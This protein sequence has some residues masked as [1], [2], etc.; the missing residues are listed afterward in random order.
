MRNTRKAYGIAILLFFLAFILSFSIGRYPIAPFELIKI[1]FSRIIPIERTW[2]SQMETVVFNI[3]LPRVVLSLLI[4]ASLSVSG[5]SLQSVFSNPMASQDVL[6]A[7]QAAAFGASLALLTG[8]GYLAMTLSSFFFGLLSVALVIL[9][10]RSM[11]NNQMLALILGGILISSLFSSATSFIKLIADTENILPA[12]T[13][14]LM[15]SLASTRTSD[16]VL[17]IIV[18]SVAMVPLILISYRLNALTLSS[19]EAESIGVD[20]KKLRIA[21]IC[22]ATFLTSSSVAVSGQI[23]WIGLVI[24]H[25]SRLILGNNTKDTLPLSAILGAAFLTF[26]D[27]ISRSITTS[28]IPLGILTS[29]IGAPVFLY[30]I[31]AEGRK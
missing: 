14:F 13:Y 15:G 22:L 7:S 12:I 25:F 6:G 24:P 31:I 18:V 21:V 28:E 8:T 2:N 3:R 11:R 16:I 5:I 17:M 23:S 26:V 19:D 9:I 29:F 4:G 20:I 1:L 30:L 10:S 27:T